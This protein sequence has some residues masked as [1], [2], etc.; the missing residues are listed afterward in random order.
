MISNKNYYSHVSKGSNRQLIEL[1]RKSIKLRY[2][3]M[4]TDWTDK[5]LI[6]KITKLEKSA[7]KI[8]RDMLKKGTIITR[9]DFFRAAHF[10]HHSSKFQDYAMAATLYQISGILGDEWGKNHHALAIDRFLLSTKQ[11]QYFGTQYEKRDSK[12]ILSPYRTRVSNKIRQEHLVPS[13][14]DTL[15]NIKNLNKQPK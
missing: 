4:D 1:F 14:K 12:W 9:D 10:F 6:E 3:C 8:I 2:E 11:K 13:L 7:L 15:N 5:S